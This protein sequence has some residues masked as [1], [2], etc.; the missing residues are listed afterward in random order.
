[1]SRGDEGEVDRE[2]D[3]RDTDAQDDVG[4]EIPEAALLDHGSV[5]DATEKAGRSG[6]HQ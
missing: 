6:S 4:D 3:D 1:V 2:R 5:S